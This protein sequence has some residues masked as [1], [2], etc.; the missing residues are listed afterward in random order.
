MMAGRVC[1]EARSICWARRIG[2]S[3]G[4]SLGVGF[5]VTLPLGGN[6]WASVDWQAILPHCTHAFIRGQLSVRNLITMLGRS[7]NI[8]VISSIEKSRQL[9]AVVFTSRHLAC[10]SRVSFAGDTDQCSSQLC[11]GCM[12]TCCW[13]VYLLSGGTSKQVQGGVTLGHVPDAHAAVCNPGKQ[14]NQLAS[15]YQ[16]SNYHMQ[17]FASPGKIDTQ[18]ASLHLNRIL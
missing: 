3:V 6:V 15:Q 14:G 17:P 11:D 5:G 7:Q 4:T 16:V 12:V 8:N 10:C 13:Q 18:R 1:R 2:I 9:A